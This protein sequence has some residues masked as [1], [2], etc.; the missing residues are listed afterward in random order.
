[1]KKQRSL[2]VLIRVNGMILAALAANAFAQSTQ[3]LSVDL[4]G[5]GKIERVAWEEFANTE[6]HGS[7][8]QLVVYDAGGNAVWKGP[9]EVNPENPLVFGEWHFGVSVPEIVAD[10]DD[11]GAIELLAPAPQSDVSPTLFRVLRWADGAFFPVKQAALLES[12]RGSGSFLWSEEEKW[13]GTWI[14]SF[15]GVNGDGSLQVNV[16]RYLSE[17]PM[18]MGKANVTIIPEGFQVRDWT[19]PLKEVVSHESPAGGEG[20]DAPLA[21]R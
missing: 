13:E 15:V 18:R 2:A 8:L 9:S 17:E 5:D 21:L 10:I 11:D 7:Y 4:D 14:S 19:T 1:M 3:S 16:T 6:D 12:P 20:R